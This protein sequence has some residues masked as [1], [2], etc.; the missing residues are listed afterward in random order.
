M[1]IFLRVGVWCSLPLQRV[2]QFSKIKCRFI[3]MISGWSLITMR[4]CIFSLNP[5]IRSFL[6][7][8][9]VVVLRKKIFYW[10]IISYKSELSHKTSPN[11]A[12]NLFSTLLTLHRSRY[13]I[14]NLI[15]ICLNHTYQPWTT[16]LTI[17]M[18]FAFNLNSN[19]R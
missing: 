15:T 16:K 4:I 6:F 13:R 2:L 8:F 17:S 14:Y 1:I 19:K 12:L 9:V 11:N 3:R 7:D 5:I 10:R 18:Y